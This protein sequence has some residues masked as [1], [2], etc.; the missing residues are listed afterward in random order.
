MQR[1]RFIRTQFLATAD[2]RGV[3]MAA[4]IS[5]RLIWAPSEMFSLTATSS[6]SA[7]SVKTGHCSTKFDFLPAICYYK[8]FMTF[9]Q[10]KSWLQKSM[11]SSCQCVGNVSISFCYSK[12]NVITTL[13]ISWFCISEID[14]SRKACWRCLGARPT[15]PDDDLL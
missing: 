5:R 3:S 4:S 8:K 15:I 10:E 1:A 2:N 11:W 12:N 14:L 9:C 6:N 7:S 13:D